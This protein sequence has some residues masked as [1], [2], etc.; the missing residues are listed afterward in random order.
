[1]SASPRG[2]S[3]EGAND[4]HLSDWIPLSSESDRWEKDEAQSKD[5][6]ALSAQSQKE[7]LVS[8]FGD[9]PAFILK[10]RCMSFLR[11]SNVV[12]HASLFP[13]FF[14]L[15]NSHEPEGQSNFAE[16]IRSQ[17]DAAAT[18]YEAMRFA[19][20]EQLYTVALQV[21]TS[22][23]KLRA[24]LHR[25]RALA[26]SKQGKYYDALK[27]AKKAMK[28]DTRYGHKLSRKSYAILGMLYGRLKKQD[29]AEKYLSEG[30]R[31]YPD[32]HQLQ[33]SLVEI[34]RCRLLER[35]NRISMSPSGKSISTGCVVD[36]AMLCV[37]FGATRTK[38]LFS[39]SDK[40]WV[41][42]AASSTA[43]WCEPA[44]AAERLMDYVQHQLTSY[45]S[46]HV[47]SIGT[48]AICTPG[49]PRIADD[50]QRTGFH[51]VNKL[52]SLLTG[53]EYDGFDFQQQFSKHAL[54]ADAAITVV[55][56]GLAA[57]LGARKKYGGRSGLVLT[58]GTSPSA[59]AFVL[60]D[61]EV[62]EVGAFQN[63]VW[64]ESIE[65]TDSVGAVKTLFG[66]GIPLHDHPEK[67]REVLQEG[68]PV[69]VG[70][71]PD[72]ARRRAFIRF[73]LDNDSWGR[74]IECN[75]RRKLAKRIWSMRVTA[76]I[77]ALLD[78]FSEQ[79]HMLPDAVYLLG[80]NSQSCKRYPFRTPVPVRIPDNDDA[81]Q[82]IHTI[83]GKHWTSLEVLHIENVGR[84]VL[85]RGWTSG[86]Q[87][88][89]FREPSSEEPLRPSPPST[90][91]PLPPSSV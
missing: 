4:G 65:V 18:L 44:L 28:M 40:L 66:S 13:F 57:V 46:V 47:R 89:R 35:N 54:F 15:L 62:L 21:R 34:K 52:P 75:T 73:A 74:I 51:V 79:Y 5:F 31:M 67:L 68:H 80:G 41:L 71:H 20:A 9:T 24:K 22:D 45:Y 26:R 43:I 70:P 56:D 50:W 58:L 29:K 55:W 77:N 11:N 32:D 16:V 8:Q 17:K 10:E 72:Q 36:H 7:A 61:G 60:R 84:D 3:S 91:L 90:T 14:E 83:G 2:H 19:E 81:V 76:A 78:R 53:V 6:L 30:L 87:I 48:L 82:Y 85:Q 33:Q 42:E 37:D 63:W 64:F 39:F 25:R 38:F 49:M 12:S 59:G 69:E 27:D 88:W 23:E 1:M 86:G